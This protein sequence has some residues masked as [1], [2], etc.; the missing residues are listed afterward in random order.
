MKYLVK[1]SVL[2]IFVFANLH[3]ICVIADEAHERPI[4]SQSYDPSRDP[5]SDLVLATARAEENNRLILLIVGGY[6]CSWCITLDRYLEKNEEFSTLFYRT[7]E[8]VKIYYGSENE[9]QMFLSKFP[10]ITGYPHFFIM[11]ANFA[12]VGNQTTG[13]LEQRKRYP[14]SSEHYEEKR[15]NEFLDKWTLYLQRPPGQEAAY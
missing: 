11:D 7:F 14:L 2:I 8:V 6:W 5:T 1:N 10:K 3:A 15:M 9:N 4:Y 13:S 12:L